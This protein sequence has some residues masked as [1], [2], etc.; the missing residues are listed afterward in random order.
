[1]RHTCTV[2]GIDIEVVTNCKTLDRRLHHVLVDS[3]ENVPVSGTVAIEIQKREGNYLVIEG[4]EAIISSPDAEWIT[5]Y[6]HE[7]I[8]FRVAWHLKEF[9]KIHAASGAFRGKRFL[10]VGDKG[11]GKTTLITR[12]LFE[13]AAVYGDETVLLQEGDVM[14]FPRKFHLKEGT[15]PLLPQ[16][17]P[18][19]DKL[20]SY[21]AYYGGR[22][23]FVDPTNAGF[24]WQITKGK[25]DSLFYLEPA[26]GEQ[27]EIQRC[28]DWLMVQKLLLQS[29]GF[30]IS[31]ESQIGELCHLV[32]R[33]DN[34]IIHLGELDSAVMLIKDVLA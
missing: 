19:C 5:L 2:I 14:P 26:H 15:L 30:A 9:I 25:V 21:P 18:I 32:D 29:S 7:L 1:M 27:S 8:N 11:A 16:L 12:L 13:G 28:P 17:A 20:T 3:D 6:L 10:L 24:D 23:F 22:F 4:G 33:S 31:P 34:F